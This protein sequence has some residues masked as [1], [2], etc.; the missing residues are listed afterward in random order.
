MSR[1]YDDQET[2]KS[3]DAVSDEYARRFSD[4]LSHKPFDRE[5]LDRFAARLRGEGPV[6]DLGCGPGQI[7]RYLRDRGVDVCG[8]DLSA[9]MIARAADAYPDIPFRTGDMRRL[10]VGDGAWAGASAFYS[11]IHIP[12]DDVT[13]T[14]VELR[15]ALRPGGLL[16]MTCHVG[17][18]TLHLDE[19]FGAEVDLDFHFFERHEMEGYLEKAGF[20][21]EEVLERGPYE[22]VEAQTRRAYFSAERP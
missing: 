8:I 19:W 10:D 14:L 21:I 7:T 1:A 17:D 20:E 12:R 6:A 16:L 11:I 2:G 22:E 9:Q 15:R 18:E 13:A 5:V 4:E 3:Y